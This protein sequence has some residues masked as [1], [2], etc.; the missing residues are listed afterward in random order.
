MKGGRYLA[1]GY[2]FE[3]SFG[4]NRQDLDETLR[5]KKKSG[6]R[7]QDSLSKDHA[8]SIRKLLQEQ[9]RRKQGIRHDHRDGKV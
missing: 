4:G 7:L 1:G 2:S 5:S 9:E 3:R 8:I 6:S